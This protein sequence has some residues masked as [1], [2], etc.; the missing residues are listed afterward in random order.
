MAGAAGEILVGYDG[1][2]GSERVGRVQGHRCAAPSC[3]KVIRFPQRGPH[4]HGQASCALCPPCT[5]GHPGRAAD[6]RRTGPWDP[7]VTGEVFG[8]PA[9]IVLNQAENNLHGI[10]AAMLAVLPGA[11][12]HHRP[13][14]VISL[15]RT[16]VISA[17]R[18][19][20]RSGSHQPTEAPPSPRTRV[21]GPVRIERYPGLT[22]LMPDSDPP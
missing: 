12:E 21:A 17:G 19:G 4:R 13:V 6:L 18:Y 10:K 8:S 1:S 20:Q 16:S 5:T 15:G 3:A 9:S 22:Q 2:A 14:R 7:E 11:A